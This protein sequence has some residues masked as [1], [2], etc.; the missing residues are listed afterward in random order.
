MFKSDN[1]KINEFA[2]Q[3]PDNMARMILMVSLSIQQQWSGVGKAIEDVDAKGSNSAY[4][5][6]SK[7][8]CYAYLQDNKD[9]IYSDAMAATT[10][11]EL[12]IVFL[13]V[14]GLGL[15]KA[16]FTCQLWNGTVGCIDV[17][18][19]RRL[20]IPASTL[21]VSKTASPSAIEKRAA[22]YVT[23]CNNYSS[24]WL[25]N[26]WCEL[27]AVKYPKKFTGVSHVSAVHYGYLVQGV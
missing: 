11:V 22:A 14:P 4:L 18:N 19:L 1:P 8:T 16:G 9:A 2:Q 3:S 27:I 12:M 6:G 25:W 10:D 13:R 24:E 5:W 26:S 7:A 15:P 21:T 23:A 17:H 20:S